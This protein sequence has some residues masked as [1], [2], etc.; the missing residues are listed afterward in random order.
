LRRGRK[1]APACRSMGE[2]AGK[3]RFLREKEEVW[4]RGLELGGKGKRREESRKGKGESLLGGSE[5]GS[6]EKVRITL[7]ADPEFE[8]LVGGNIVAA[9]DLLEEDLGLPWGVIGKDGSGDQLELRP[10]PS[11]AP[12][13]LVKNVGRLLLSVPRGVGGLPST[14]GE[15]YPLGGHVHIGGLAEG[16]VEEVLEAVDEAFGRIFYGMNSKARLN[17]SYGQVGDWRAQP[18][19]AEYRTPPANVWSH[20]GVALV[21]LRAIK[22]VAERVLEGEDPFRHPAWAF[23]RQAAE[24]AA[25]FVRAHNGRL[26]WGAWK[27][28]IARGT[29]SGEGALEV[30]V[31]AGPQVERDEAFV[32]D[33]ALMCRRLGIP[34]VEIIPL[35]R[36]RGEFASNVPGYGQPVE[37]FAPYEPLGRLALSWRFRNDYEFRR[38]ELP[39]LEEA[40]ARLLERQERGDRGRLVREVVPFAVALPVDLLEEGEEVGVAWD[41]GDSV[42]CE[43]CG[44]VME[45]AEAHFNRSGEAF[46]EECYGERYEV[47]EGCGREIE[48]ESAGYDPHTGDAY[49]ER[50]YRERYVTCTSCD[51]AVLREVARRSLEGRPYCEDCY[52][53]AY[54]SCEGCGEEVAREE[55]MLHDDL[56]YCPSCYGSLFVSCGRCGE[57][58]LEEEAYRLDDGTP[59][60]EECFFLEH[61]LCSNCG[62][63]VL[64]EEAPRTEGAFY[65]EACYD[66]LFAREGVGAAEA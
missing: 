15:E 28:H 64:K 36:E 11:C 48:A 44:L 34:W 17:S 22:W 30:V 13:A 53:E 61:D 26:H 14:M 60:C 56:P 40:I 2:A 57:E 58:V 31:N 12:S 39:R 49:C 5:G 51:E 7:G 19:G 52:A 20:P 4:E 24:E 37:G 33:I 50:C 6:M 42:E 29:P 47:C 9:E 10:R 3:V 54:T 16:E 45:R 43:G 27:E 18:W 66:H 35:H 25:E 23:V 62:E 41:S 38:K 21:F 46:C 55:A 8:L 1:T 32:G 59:F 63:V 65:C